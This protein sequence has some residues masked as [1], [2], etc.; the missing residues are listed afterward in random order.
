MIEDPP[1]ASNPDILVRLD[2]LLERYE[3][4]GGYAGTALILK[5]AKAEITRLRAENAAR[6]QPKSKKP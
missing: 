6:P 5:D 1:Q 3:R 2:Y 4:Q